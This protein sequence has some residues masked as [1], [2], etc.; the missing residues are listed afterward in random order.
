MM[1]HRQ[2][3]I[4][5]M[6]SAAAARPRVGQAAY[7]AA[8]AGMEG[9]ARGAAPELGRFGVRVNVCA[10]GFVDAGL[11]LSSEPLREAQWAFPSVR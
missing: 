5:L 3:S 1:R 2:G 10:P 11:T 7:A 9:L 6:G 8:K 4:V